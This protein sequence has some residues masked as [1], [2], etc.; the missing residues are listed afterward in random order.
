MRH[1]IFSITAPIWACLFIAITVIE[2]RAV[3]PV[4]IAFALVCLA[5]GRMLRVLS[6][7][8]PFRHIVITLGTIIVWMAVGLLWA[9]DI[10]RAMSTLAK[11]TGNCLVGMCIIAALLDADTHDK[12]RIVHG[13][14]A[15]GAFVVFYMG[16]DIASYGKLDNLLFGYIYRPVYGY[17]WLKPAS[18]LLTLVSWA[19]A[20]VAWRKSHRA[21]A[22]LAVILG[23]GVLSHFIGFNASTPALFAALVVFFSVYWWGKRIAHSVVAASVVFILLMPVPLQFVKASDLTTP[24]QSKST[25]GRSFTHRMLIWEYASGRIRQRPVF[26][27]GLGA[28]QYF[29]KTERFHD[30]RHRL[31]TEVIPLHPHNGALQIW[32]EL[33][34]VGVILVV[35]IFWRLGRVFG[36]STMT[37]IY[38]ATICGLFATAMTYLF[39]SFG[40]W[41]SWWQQYLWFVAALSVALTSYTSTEKR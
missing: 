25:V 2:Q 30:H 35:A 39:V 28:S 8:A 14:L 1:L 26:G 13:A 33:G 5:Q 36:S 16:I 19:A 12:R 7:V 9:P 37:P 4:S 21:I 38:R 18:A 27:W 15:G 32:L 34:A 17:F 20:I 6:T 24:E 41:S 10:D 11:F 22:V 29:G 3:V 23:I 40:L 31:Y